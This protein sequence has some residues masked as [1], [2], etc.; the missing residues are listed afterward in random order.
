MPPKKKTTQVEN[1]IR[2]LQAQM[3]RLMATPQAKPSAGRRKKARRSK[4]PPL[5]G[6]ASITIKHR[7]LMA[8]VLLASTSRDASAT[9]ASGSL[10][11]KPSAVGKV[12]KGL[13]AIYDTYR[14]MAVSFT[15]HSSSSAMKNGS[16]SMGVDYNATSGATPAKATVLALSPHY[17]GNLFKSSPVMKVPSS[18]IKPD[19][20]RQTNPAQ[21]AAEVPFFIIWYADSE[22]QAT[23]TSLGYIE[24]EY[25]LQFAGIRP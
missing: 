11:F 15:F 19:L 10:A 7:E 20:V 23:G 1:Q 22:S 24:V 16:F 25:H 8:D 9:I 18:V 13:S 5:V 6:G 12:L 4:N 17:S 21:T 3:Q 14:V 2:G